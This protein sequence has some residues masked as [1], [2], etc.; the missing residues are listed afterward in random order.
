[1]T[2]VP[3]FLNDW[4]IFVVPSRFESESFGV[5]AVEASAAGLPVIVSDVGGLPEVVDHERTGLVVRREDPTALADAIARLIDNP[6][7]RQ[8]LGSAGRGKVEEMYD[9]RKNVEQMIQI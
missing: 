8:R 1:N 2:E 3:V 4:D 6:E 5:A 7:E 9:W